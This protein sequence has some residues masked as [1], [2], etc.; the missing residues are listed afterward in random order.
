MSEVLSANTVEIRFPFSRFR[1]S[2]DFI[3]PETGE[4]ELS[5]TKQSFKDECDFNR[6]ME[7]WSATSLN[8][9]PARGVP[10]YGDFSAVGDYLTSLQTVIDA[11]DAFMSLPAVV[12]DRFSNDPGQLL[13][14]LQD[15]ANADE[16]QRLG[17][18]RP[19]EKG[20]VNPEADALASKAGEA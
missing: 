16:A 8:P 1:V 9:H 20:V 17:L 19:V 14:F 6:V 7:T 18:L 5:M 12:R 10:R 15:P 4:P 3:D 11:Q 2:L 13:A